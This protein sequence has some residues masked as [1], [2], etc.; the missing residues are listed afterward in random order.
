MPFIAYPKAWT[1]GTE[2]AVRG[3]VMALRKVDSEADLQQYKGM[4]GR[5][6]PLPRRAA[7]AQGTGKAAA[8]SLLGPG[9]RLSGDV[10]V[11]PERREGPNREGFLKRLRLQKALRSFLVEE[12]ALATVEPSER[13]SGVVR[14]AGGGSRE[15]GENPAFLPW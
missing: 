4:L 11:R 12:G 3:P 6:D 9:A 8:Q 1:P 14:V 2:G 13:D 5:Q 15:P 7:R 10:P